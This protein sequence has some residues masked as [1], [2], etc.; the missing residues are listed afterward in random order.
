M[1]FRREKPRIPS[2]DERLKTLKQMGIRSAKKSSDHAVAM[3][4]QCAAMIRQTSETGYQIDPVGIVVGNEIGELVD[5][6]NQKYW[7]T[8]SGKREPATAEQLHALHA[9][10]EDL[11]EGLDL[12]SLYNEG[13]GTVNAL[14]LYDRVQDRD[15]GVPRRP[16]EKVGA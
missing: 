10:T 8:P 7:L 6:G 14:H 16:W 3:R 9:F 13:L 12:K 15:R 5:A 4:G 2:F 11:R 1:F